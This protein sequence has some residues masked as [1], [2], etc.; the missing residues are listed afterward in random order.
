MGERMAVTA[1]QI[2]VHPNKYAIRI[3]DPDPMPEPA[4]PALSD[5][6]IA[7]T[8]GWDTVFAINLPHVNEALKQPGS[9]PG[10]FSQFFSSTYAIAGTFGTWQVAMGGDGQDIY[11][12]VP[13]A[14]GSTLNFSNSTYDMAGGLATVMINLDYVP[15][16]PKTAPVPDD[17]KGTSHNLTAKTTTSDPTNQ[18]IAAVIHFAFPEGSKASGNTPTNRALFQ[19]ALTQWFIDNLER[20]Q[21]VFS[22]VNL[23]EKADKASFQW[24]KPSLTSYAYADGTKPENSLLGVLTT[25]QRRSIANL[26]HQIAPSAIPSGA[27]SGFLISAELFLKQS[28]LPGLPHAFKNASASDFQLTNHGSEITL[29]PGVTVDV[30]DVEYGGS[31]YHPKMSSFNLVIDDTEIVTNMVVDVDISPGISITITMTNYQ[32]L[33]LVTKT[34]GTQTLGYK[35][36]RPPKQTYVKH[37]A[38]WVKVT[39][40]IISLIVAVIGAV[41]AGPGA[42]LADA[43]IVAIIVAIIIGIIVGIQLII[44]DVIAK[45]VA[46][47]MPSINPMV[48]AATDPIVWPTAASSFT[49]TSA[50]LNGALQFGGTL[51]F[52][53]PQGTS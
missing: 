24:L 1:E 46:E 49:L 18:P 21:H 13:I 52:P 17:A 14:D 37:V 35:N 2:V 27:Q 12:R 23:A 5:V 42:A 11:L 41:V 50:G 20:F 4:P 36:T 25:T 7:D 28:I 32:T 44:E 22:T 29:A 53:I 16:V 34:D 47:A 6:P 15:S 43:I 39:T 51:N 26:S 30:N 45:G 31:T 40:A 10:G 3:H 8:L 33:T 48:Y 19:G 38:A 9:A